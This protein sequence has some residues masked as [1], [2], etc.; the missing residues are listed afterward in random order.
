MFRSKSALIMSGTLLVAFG[1]VLA[2]IARSE[3]DFDPWSDAHLLQ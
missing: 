3:V 2:R 1:W